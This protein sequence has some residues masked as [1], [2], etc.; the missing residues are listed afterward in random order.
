M[1]IDNARNEQCRGNLEITN[2]LSD[3]SMAMFS[4]KLGPTCAEATDFSEHIKNLAYISK[5]L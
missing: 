1:V 4:C 5:L 3:V 2:L